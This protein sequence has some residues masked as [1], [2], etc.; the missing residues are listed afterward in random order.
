[1]HIL[2]QCNLYKCGLYKWGTS[3]SGEI[4]S[5]FVHFHRNEPLLAGKWGMG[6]LNFQGAIIPIQNDLYK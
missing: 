1:M 2:I 3:I 4:L 6:D 5:I